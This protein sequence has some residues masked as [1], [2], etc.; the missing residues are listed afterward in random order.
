MDWK[1]VVLAA[2]FSVL[3]LFMQPVGILAAVSLII[4]MLVKGM[5]NCRLSN[6]GL[7]LEFLGI[8]LYPL[9]VLNQYNIISLGTQIT[10]YIVTASGYLMLIGV[11]LI[12]IGLIIVMLGLNKAKENIYES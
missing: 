11:I 7:L 2:I 6:I 1:K 4:Y 5:D 8:L 12:M 3:A 9:F 10:G